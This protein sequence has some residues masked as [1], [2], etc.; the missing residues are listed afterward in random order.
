MIGNAH[1]EKLLHIVSSL[2]FLCLAPLDMEVGSVTIH[3]Q[4]LQLVATRLVLSSPSG[5]NLIEAFFDQDNI[6][7]LVALSD[8]TF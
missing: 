6:R 3:V 4:V 7:Q 1:I 2:S 8:N 5:A